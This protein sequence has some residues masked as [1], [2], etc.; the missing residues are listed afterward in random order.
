M[1]PLMA[2]GIVKLSWPNSCELPPLAGEKPSSTSIK[3]VLPAPFLPRMPTMLPAV[4]CTE[5]SRRMLFLPMLLARPRA[6]TIDSVTGLLHLLI[7]ELAQVLRVQLQLPGRQHQRVHLRL[8]L[9]Q[10]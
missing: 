6:L 7:D 10:A 8:D 4:T 9:L 1:R 3:V 2:A 5:T